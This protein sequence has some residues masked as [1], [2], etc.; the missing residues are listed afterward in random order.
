MVADVFTHFQDASWHP[1]DT[2]G[3]A[4]THL[5]IKSGQLL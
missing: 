2:T 4:V 3:V 1:N 5:I